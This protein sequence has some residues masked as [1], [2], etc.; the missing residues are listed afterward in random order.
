MLPATCDNHAVAAVNDHTQSAQRLYFL[1]L[2]RVVAGNQASSHDSMQGLLFTSPRAGGP[3]A[4]S[5]SSS[6]ERCHFFSVSL[7]CPHT[8]AYES[9]HTTGVRAGLSNAIAPAGTL[10]PSKVIVHE[11]GPEAMDTFFVCL[12][13][14]E[15]VGVTIQ[16]TAVG[17]K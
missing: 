17:Q 3:T 9:T 8:S 5:V 7:R 4:P 1:T 2:R 15:E 14:F 6:L 16:F 11:S 10:A 12:F 13:A